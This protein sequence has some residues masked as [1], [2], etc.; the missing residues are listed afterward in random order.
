MTPASEC[1]VCCRSERS[2]WEAEAETHTDRK[3][4]GKKKKKKTRGKEDANGI[5][6]PLLLLPLVNRCSRWQ[7][8]NRWTREEGH[9]AER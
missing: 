6:S 7:F 5:R 1:Q 3:T 9:E 8:C 4:K 2:R